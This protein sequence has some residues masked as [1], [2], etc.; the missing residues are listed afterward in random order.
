VSCP[1]RR[2]CPGEPTQSENINLADSLVTSGYS[3]DQSFF[4][5]FN[6]LNQYDQ[7]GDVIYYDSK[8]E[9]KKSSWGALW[10]LLAFI[11]LGVFWY[12]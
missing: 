3:I 6:G 7:E 4:A 5:D 9:N 8:N 12:D 2:R 1:D 10:G 11:T